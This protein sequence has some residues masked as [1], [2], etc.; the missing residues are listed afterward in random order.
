MMIRHVRAVRKLPHH[1]K[2]QKETAPEEP[3]ETVQEEAPGI[4]PDVLQEREQEGHPE[5]VQKDH[6]GREQDVLP[7]KLREVQRT[8]ALL[9]GQE[10]TNTRKKQDLVREY[11][12]ENRLRKNAD[13]P[14]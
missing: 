5:P 9:K 4:A 8:D 11:P 13:A 1:V 6:P 10:D 3:A 14:F 2:I 12:K 7:G